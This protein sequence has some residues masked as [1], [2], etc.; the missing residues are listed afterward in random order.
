MTPDKVL[1]RFISLE[2]LSA[3]QRLPK[4][5]LVRWWDF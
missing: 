4:E 5:E 2:Y 3:E 1:K